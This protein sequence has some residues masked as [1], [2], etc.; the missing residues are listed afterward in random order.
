MKSEVWYRNPWVWLIIA[1]PMSAVIGGIATIILTNQ[2][3][4][5]MV[6]D[7]YYKK[8]KAI[9]QELTLY[10][11]AEKLGVNLELKINAHRVEIKSTQQYTALKL[12]VIHSTLSEQDFDLVLTPNAAGTLSSAVDKIMPGKW[13]VVVSPMDNAWKV[14]KDVALPNSN[15]INL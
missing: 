11:N 10:N 6:I 8:G 14:R 12:K 15:W 9:N 7:D 2:N 13:Q 5:N 1:L 3:Q 4:P